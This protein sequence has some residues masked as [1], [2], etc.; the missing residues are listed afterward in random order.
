MDS[1]KQKT[2]Q[3][4]HHRA[5]VKFIY[6][7]IIL[8]VTA[9]VL[10]TYR[11]FE[12]L[13]HDAFQAFE[14]FSVII[15]TIEYVVRLWTSSLNPDFREAF[16]GRRIRFAFSPLGL[17]DLLAIV[18]FYLPMLIPIDLRFVRILRLLRLLRIFKL[19][20]FSKSLK[21]IADVLVE[22]KEELMV[23][24]FI[25]FILLIFSAS[26]MYYI[27]VEVQPDKF[28]SIGHSI[29]WA[30]AT[31]TTVGYGDIYPIT[32]L[33]KFLAGVIALIGVGLVA[34]PTGIISSAFIEKMQ[35]SKQK[36]QVCTCPNCGVVFHRD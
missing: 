2:Y 15:F 22:T 29:W 25:S 8:N 4:L 18:P 32:G 27:E 26:L 13:Y 31:L 23:T 9:L 12:G 11:E 21:S 1:I 17:I 30:V 14:T 6:V 5:T 16:P 3:L 7:L 33:G 35:Q 36:K 10:E 34:L 24:I 28:E 19:G 20:R